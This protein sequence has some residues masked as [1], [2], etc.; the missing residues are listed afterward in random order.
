MAAEDDPKRWLGDT[1]ML[2]LR[3]DK[4][5]LR[6]KTVT[7]FSRNDREKLVA[8]ANYVSGIPF[9]VPPFAPARYTRQVLSRRHAVGWYSKAALFQAM[10]RVAGFPARV[11]MIR[12]GHDMYRGLAPESGVFVLPVVEVHTGGRWIVTDCYVY[13]LPYLAVAREAVLRAGWRSGY[14]VH[15]DGNSE[16]DGVNDALVMLGPEQ[17][18]DPANHAGVFDDPQGYA[19]TLRSRSPAL[20]WWAAA[21]NRLMSIRL[22]RQVRRLRA[23]AGG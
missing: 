14:G 3:D 20:G 15:V 21:R 12:V 8:I 23:E 13:D 5:R 16:W 7:Q 6:V 19:E 1:P 17:A 18:R 22:H 4:L 2:N 9:D 10:L 11:R